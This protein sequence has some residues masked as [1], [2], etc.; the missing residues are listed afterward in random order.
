MHYPRDAFP[1]SHGCPHPPSP[2][3]LAEPRYRT[4]FCPL[5]RAGSLNYSL[6]II[7]ASPGS[8]PS[9]SCGMGEAERSQ[10]GGG[11]RSPGPSAGSGASVRAGE[12][13]PAPRPAPSGR[14]APTRPRPRGGARSW[15]AAQR[16]GGLGTRSVPPRAG[17]GLRAELGTRTRGTRRPLRAA[18]SAPNGD[19][20][21][22]GSPGAGV[23]RRGNPPSSQEGVVW[24]GEALAWVTL[25]RRRQSLPP[26]RGRMPRAPVVPSPAPPSLNIDPYSRR[27]PPQTGRVPASLPPPALPAPGAP[28]RATRRGREGAGGAG[29]AGTPGLPKVAGPPRCH[30]PRSPLTPAAAAVGDVARRGAAGV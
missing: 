2:C 30:R 29:R 24:R 13:A 27:P 12:A 5:G 15:A 6:K 14:R 4:P 22:L 18:R 10:V 19:W 20:H 3:H 21:L 26:G 23:R 25:R 7:P 8:L 11:W 9:Y 17:R 28:R 16:R 1:T